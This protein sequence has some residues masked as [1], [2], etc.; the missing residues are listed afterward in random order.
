M[1]DEKTLWETAWAACGQPVGEHKSP[2][3]PQPTIMQNAVIAAAIAN[4]GVVQNPYLVEQ[5]L[6]PEGTVISATSPKTLGQAIAP[7]TAGL[8][9]QAMLSVITE[10]TGQAA[11]IPGVT[12][13][14]KT[15]TAQMGNNKINSLFISF[16][17]YDT[18]TL[19]ISLCIEGKA[20]EDIQGD[21]TRMAKKVLSRALEAHIQGS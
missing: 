21:A 14:G 15:G 2:A 20:G 16:A 5:I 4:N 12:I 8:L 6:S 7:K 13:A 10:G 3:G 9:K 11:K 17:P 1:S 19:A 18:P